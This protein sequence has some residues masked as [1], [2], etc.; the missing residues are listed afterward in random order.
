MHRKTIEFNESTALRGS[1]PFIPQVEV[2]RMKNHLT[3]GRVLL[4]GLL[5]C[6]VGALGC[7]RLPSDVKPNPQAIV[8]LRA[9]FQK[10]RGAGE[11]SATTDQP[12]ADPVG[13]GTLRGV[14]K[15][16]GTAPDRQFLKVD[17]D[18]T[19]CGVTNKIMSEDL[20]VSSEGG[21]RDVLIFVNQKLAD[22]EPWTHPSAKLGKSDEVIF[23]Q[24]GCV[25]TTHLLALQSSQPIRISNSDSVG[26]NANLAA[27]ANPRFDQTVAGNASAVYQPTA[28]ERQPFPVSCA[29]HPW[30]K[31][32][33][34]MRN[35]SYF[36][37]SSA[38][39]SF[40][41]ANLPA[42]V[43][44]EF[45]VWQER[46]G[47]VKKAKVGGAEAKWSGGKFKQQVKAD[48]VTDFVVELDAAS[49]K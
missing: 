33:I 3:L 7:S 31:A 32:W 14:F 23:D 34:I 27:N 47:F 9:D 2:H 13:W 44:L 48:G 26:H 18:T 49:F 22:D 6:M 24:K 12:L 43:D 36:A 15:L 25:F 35:N 29:I 46:T 42:G 39:G 37:V 1:L 10:V 16:G 19:V 40:E 20:V 5:S 21:I 41:I 28:E 45:R 4:G 8:K 30:M 11:S 38:D 17:K